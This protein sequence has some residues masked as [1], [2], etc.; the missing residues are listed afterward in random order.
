ML[1]RMKYLNH[2]LLLFNFLKLNIVYKKEIRYLNVSPLI[3]YG[4]WL[5]EKQRFQ[6]NSFNIANRKHIDL[7]L[8]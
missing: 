2:E 8:K 4:M 1:A 7:I 5:S 3:G 6:G